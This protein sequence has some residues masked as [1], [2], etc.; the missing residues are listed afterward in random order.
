MTIPAAQQPPSL[1]EV[2]AE[3]YRI[4]TCPEGYVGPC[5]GPTKADV[6]QARR[7]LTGQET[8]K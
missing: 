1:A 7:N 3:A 5:W 2:R 8:P 6:E 4:H